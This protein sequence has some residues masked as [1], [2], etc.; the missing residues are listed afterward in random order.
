MGDEEKPKTLVNRVLME[1]K[2]WVG[3]LRYELF[4]TWLDH[5]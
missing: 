1:S 3:P 4:Q 5:L 2:D